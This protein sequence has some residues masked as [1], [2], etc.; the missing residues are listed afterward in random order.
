MKADVGI[1]QRFLGGGDAIDY[2]SGLDGC[3][4]LD[5]PQ[6]NRAELEVPSRAAH[7]ANCAPIE[8]RITFG[9]QRSTV[10]GSAIVAVAPS[11]AAVRRMVPALPGS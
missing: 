9:F 6:G 3:A 8:L 10:P 7:E 1:D 4:A 5:Q 11:A 2:Q